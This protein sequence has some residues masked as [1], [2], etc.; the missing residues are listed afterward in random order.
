MK[1]FPYTRLG[2]LVLF[3]VFLSACGSDDE[4]AET[5]AEQPAIAEPEPEVTA[6]EPAASE[7]AY[8]EAMK[9]VDDLTQRMQVAQADNCS[10]K[11]AEDLLAKAQEALDDGNEE[12]ALSFAADA[13]RSLDARVRRC[14]QAKAAID[15]AARLIRQART[16][17]C[18]LTKA[19]RLVDQAR[20][21]MSS[22]RAGRALDIA[23]DAQ[24]AIEQER[25]ACIQ[26]A[27]AED[28]PEPDS[29][30]LSYTVRRGDNLWDIAG[31]A[32]IYGDSFMWPLIYKQ[33]SGAI[34]DPDLIFPDQIFSIQTNP[35]EQDVNDAINH[36]RT[37]GE[38]SLDSLEASDVR[39]LRL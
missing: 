9:A 4:A 7:P 15:E 20:D 37:R 36:A 33:N 3:A 1:N 22:G 35:L 39:Y 38:W 29:K 28:M 25:E 27:K 8:S 16:D 26:K 18:S 17:D 6:S 23:D 13:K 32:S 10:S 11:R 14:Q 24:N 5:Q 31:K 2:A 19:A 12:L 34:E 30:L 21:A